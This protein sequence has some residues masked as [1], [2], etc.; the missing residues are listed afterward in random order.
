M[1]LSTLGSIDGLNFFLPLTPN[2]LKYFGLLNLY[3]SFKKFWNRAVL[4][5]KSCDDDIFSFQAISCRYFKQIKQFI[6][7][8]NNAKYNPR[9]HP[10]TKENKSWPILGKTEFFISKKPYS[11]QGCNDWWKLALVQ[12]TFVLDIN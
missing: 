12:K 5:Y 4:I 7:F 2:E 11:W 3:R 1:L 9:T 6:N 10:Y 8:S